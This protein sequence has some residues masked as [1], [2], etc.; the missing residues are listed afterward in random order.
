[1]LNYTVKLTIM[2][3]RFIMRGILMILTVLITSVYCFKEK[4]SFHKSL[5]ESTLKAS[6]S[7][8]SRIELKKW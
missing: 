3:Y 7:N 4:H 1:M 5:I 2:T 8:A 6:T